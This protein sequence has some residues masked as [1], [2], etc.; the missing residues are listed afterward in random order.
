MPVKS[1]LS[2]VTTAISAFALSTTL[3][4]CSTSAPVVNDAVKMDTSKTSEYSLKSGG[5]LSQH[6]SGLSMPKADLSFTIL[7]DHKAIIGHAVLTLTTVKPTS[8]FSVDLDRVF[9]INGIELNGKPLSKSQYQNTNGELV[10]TLTKPVQGMFTLDIKYDGKPRQAVRAPWDGGFDWKQTEQGKH[11]IATAVQGE[12]CDLFWPCIDQPHGEVAQMDIRISVPYDLVAASNGVLQSVTKNGDLTTYHWQTSSL[13]NTYAI[14]LNIGPYDLLEEQYTSLYGNQYP[15]QFYHLKENQ[16]QAQT[17]FDEIPTMIEFFE[18]VIGPYPFANEKMG[19]VETPH[20][21]MEHQTINAYGNKYRKDEFGY[22]WLLHHE[23]AHEWFGNQLT[24]N[25]WDHM[26]LHEGFGTYMQ[27]LYTQYLHGDIAYKAHL[28]KQRVNL[29]NKYPIVS[30]RSLSV[31]EVYDSETGPGGDIYSKGSL[32]LHTLRELIGD[33][34]FFAATRQ[35]VYGTTDPKPGNFAPRFSDTNEFISLVNY[36]TGKD[37]SWFFD[38]YLFQASLPELI[39]EST[40]TGMTLSWLVENNK[41]F[42]MPLEVSINGEIK[43]YDLAEPKS[44]KVHPTDV[45]IFDPHSKVL[46]HLPHIERYREY[47]QA[48]REAFMK[49]QKN[50]N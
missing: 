21:G 15:I 5:P 22:D 27:P 18:K 17:L 23:F 19:V 35:L 29:V 46:R 2:T 38:V 9:N 28:Y 30:N 41:P 12:G 36:H 42:P 34:A 43:T 50:N 48:Q 33:D 20:L 40:E 49:K 24:N 8:T 45:V 6:Q 25:D 37:L 10:I 7:P 14:A 1:K 11:W 47:L 39:V 16:E 3:M 4:G 13:H 32:I 44:I 26:W 31:E